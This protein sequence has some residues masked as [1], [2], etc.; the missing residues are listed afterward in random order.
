VPGLNYATTGR[1][2]FLNENTAT[3]DSI[4]WGRYTQST[5]VGWQGIPRIKSGVKEHG[6]AEYLRSIT[7]ATADLAALQW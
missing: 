5:P 1:L 6:T 3:N 2:V 4:A 7:A